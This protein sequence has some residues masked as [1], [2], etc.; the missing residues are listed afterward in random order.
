MKKNKQKIKGFTLIEGSV[1][2]IIDSMWIKDDRSELI[3]RSTF[4]D[5]W[6]FKFVEHPK[7]SNK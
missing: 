7:E 6:I 2:I 5:S 4:G 1:G 3:V